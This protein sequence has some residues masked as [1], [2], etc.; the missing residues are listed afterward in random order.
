MKK[1][2]FLWGLL[3]STF[4]QNVSAQREDVN[5]GNFSNPVPSVSSLASYNNAPQT[6]A[7]GMVAI[8]LPLLELPSRNKDISL[9]ISLSYN[10]LNADKDEPASDV[11]AG[12][13]LFGGG[14]I[15]RQVID[16]VDERHDSTTR[17]GYVKNEFNDIYYYNAAG[18]SGKFR[19]IRDI[20]NNTF[21]LVNLSSNK[22]KIE[23]T[24][25][26]NTAT[27]V[28][29]SFII[30]DTKGNKYF[31]SD[32]SRSRSEKVMSGNREFRSAF[33]LS[34]IVD[35]SNVEVANFTYE[36]RIKYQ[37]L[38]PDWLEYQ[39]C[40]L[41][42][43]NAP[44]FG[45][46]EYEYLFE[47]PWRMND[48]YQVQKVILK[49][50]NNHIISSYAFEYTHDQI[51]DGQLIGGP[52]EYIYKRMLSKIK[53]LDKNN[54]ISE[55]TGLE[56]KSL[57][58]YPSNPGG[59]PPISYFCPDLF[60]GYTGNSS[61]SRPILKRIIKPTGGVAEYN[62]EEGDLYKNRA[63]PDYLST[64]LNGSRFI[65][66]EIQYLKSFRPAIVSDTQSGLEQPFNVT[67]NGTKMLLLNLFEREVNPPTPDVD[68]WNNPITKKYL[69][70]D[71]YQNG[72]LIRG[73]YCKGEDED[74]YR[75]YYLS[76][77]NYTLKTYGTEGREG[78]AEISFMEIGH[79]QQPF[80]NS[81]RGGNFR[82][83]S[84]KYYNNVTDTAP[85]K[86]TRFE[87]KDF[88]DFSASSGYLFTQEMDE[89]SSK[90]TLYKNVKVIDDNGGYTKFYYRTPGEFPQVPYADGGANDK[91]WAN[92]SAFSDGILEKKE[93]YDAQNKL[94]VKEQSDYL[95]EE[96]PGAVS[97]QL[98]H[99]GTNGSYPK[100][101][102]KSIWL[103]KLTNTATS[104]F[105]N[106]RSIQQKSETDFGVFNFQPVKV[107]KEIDGNIEEQ[108]SIYSETG[109]PNLKNA[110][111]IN[112]PV[113]VEGKRNGVL[114]SRSETKY[115]N[116][117]NLYPSAISS[118]NIGNTAQKMGTMDLYDENG[119]IIQ[120][121]PP[122]GKPITVIY[123]YNKTQPIARIEG[124]TYAQVS[125][126]ISGIINAS[127]ADAADSSKEALLLSALDD[128]RNNSQ[129]S[130]FMIT[131]YT[132]DPLI[133]A[134][135]VTPPNG[136]REIY[137]YDSQNRLLQI[138]DM[139]GMILKEYKYNY[140]N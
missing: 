132:Y 48:P 55:T 99:V 74:G 57:I 72:T 88:T 116:P 127:D 84:I 37:P 35:A 117:T 23:Y 58:S 3:F 19:F 15:S 47:E 128:F 97:Y 106:G 94:L 51:E 119:N 130:G 92:Y 113:V 29:D 114:I 126:L 33:F 108:L 30:T 73:G 50:Q 32:Y 103:K 75:I 21:Q 53:K 85:I 110:N 18:I 31:F 78:I 109:Y 89:N 68:P 10:L 118:S 101:Y 64:V 122:D 65:D 82:I 138:V 16:L 111:M 34:K 8:G 36:K 4:S 17:N 62:Y 56:Y 2:I 63:D 14:V 39:Y 80:P 61:S 69:K 139:K 46:I 105:E 83:N 140:K 52:M 107:S 124:A 135:T 102:S 6:S 26:S 96:I 93:I 60:Y 134:T 90:Y 115:N 98:F 120:F 129:L 42:S 136:I 5:F 59:G 112:V 77:G 86:S 66:L 95:F 44:G 131:T 76:P 7:A 12:W 125:G 9:G 71:I 41:T 67:G 123:G 79:I 25:N 104:Y 43:I 22:D 91:F 81:E 28:V 40:K 70:F 11:G 121:T 24:R 133:G 27:L 100:T 20:A 137:K 13:S 45:K 49:D 87:Y 54:I 1:T 38:T